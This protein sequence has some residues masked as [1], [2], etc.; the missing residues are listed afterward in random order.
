MTLSPASLFSSDVQTVLDAARDRGAVPTLTAS[1]ADWRDQWIYFLIIDRF[2]N[3]LAP[4]RHQPFDDPAFARFQGGT[5]RGV[6]EQIPYLKELGFAR[7]KAC[8]T[9]E[10]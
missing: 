7:L 4:P 6:Q 9:A 2:N 10:K 1:P 5:F 3:R 8:A